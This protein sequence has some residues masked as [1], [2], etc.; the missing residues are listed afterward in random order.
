MNASIV[1]RVERRSGAPKRPGYLLIGRR[2]WLVLAAAVLVAGAALNWSWLVAAGIAPLLLAF[3]PC[4]AMCALGLCKK[5]GADS[6]K[7]QDSAGSPALA[8]IPVHT[9]KPSRS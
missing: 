3:A 4:A 6:C 1:P 8:P 2:T 7:Q 5:P 9:G